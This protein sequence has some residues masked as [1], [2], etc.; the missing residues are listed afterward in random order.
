MRRALVGLLILLGSNEFPGRAAGD[1]DSLRKPTDAE[2]RRLLVGKWAYEKGVEGGP[3]L[4]AT[5]HYKKDG[6]FESEGTFTADGKTL[7]IILSGTW[8]VKDGIIISTLKKTSHPT[9]IKEG[10]VSK[11]QV[12]SIDDKTLRYTT[13][14]G[15]ESIERRI[16][17]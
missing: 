10:Y 16:K 14:R 4:Q 15:T 2:I 5:N 12:I 7:N 17:E 9:M 3:K 8:E 11:D 13:E 1:G 6:I